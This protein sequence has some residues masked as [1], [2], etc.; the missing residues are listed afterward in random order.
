VYAFIIH[1]NAV[2][3]QGQ[4]DSKLSQAKQKL[5]FHFI[6]CSFAAQLS[7]QPLL[8]QLSALKVSNSLNDSFW[9]MLPLIGNR[10]SLSTYLQKL[11]NLLLDLTLKPEL[12]ISEILKLTPTSSKPL[13]QLLEDHLETLISPI[14]GNI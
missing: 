1:S 10:E 9:F 5:L 14:N 6:L 7:I 2:L 3:S 8:E 11:E 13:Q 4:Y 12:L